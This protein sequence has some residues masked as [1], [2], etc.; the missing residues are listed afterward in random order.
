MKIELLESVVVRGHAG[1]KVGDV[2]EVLPNLG[3][4]L[5]GMNLGRA[6]ETSEA[7]PEAIQSREPVIESRDPE[8]PP[9]P[10]SK[11]RRAR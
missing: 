9:A 7:V 2:L 3:A 11:P 1:A 10:P 5:I 8:T 6:V 4:E